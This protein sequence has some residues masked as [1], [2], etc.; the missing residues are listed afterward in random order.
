MARRYTR[1]TTLGQCS[2][3]LDGVAF[4]PPRRAR[5]AHQ[6]ESG[7][8]YVVSQHNGIVEAT[9]VTMMPTT[10]L[11]TCLSDYTWQMPSWIEGDDMLEGTSHKS[12]PKST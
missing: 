10:A 7:R 3:I 9:L 8:I 11:L 5:L 6:V 2:I 1:I 4:D 12:I